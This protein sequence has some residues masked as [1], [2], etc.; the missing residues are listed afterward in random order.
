MKWL[1]LIRLGTRFKTD[2]SNRPQQHGMDSFFHCR[3]D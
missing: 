3:Q 1:K 2:R